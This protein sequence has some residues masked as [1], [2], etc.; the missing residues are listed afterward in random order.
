MHRAEHLCVKHAGIDIDARI[1]LVEHLPRGAVLH[2]FR[3]QRNVVI[4]RNDIDIAAPCHIFKHCTEHFGTLFV[5]GPA[6]AERGELVVQEGVIIILIL[7][8]LRAG[9]HAVFVLHI[10]QIFCLGRAEAQRCGSGRAAR[11]HLTYLVEAFAVT[12]RG[13]DIRIRVIEQLCDLAQRGRKAVNV[14]RI[15]VPVIVGLGKYRVFAA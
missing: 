11:K 10:A 1:N 8:K 6:Y 3:L 14:D 13:D 15:I 2:I 7:V 4:Y 12:A 5:N 9:D